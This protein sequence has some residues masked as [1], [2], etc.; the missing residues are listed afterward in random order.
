M[1]SVKQIGVIKNTFVLV[2]ADLNVPLEGKKV[3]DE[4]RIRALVPTLTLLKKKGAKIIVISHIGR[5]PEETLA[6]VAKKLSTYIP[7][8]FVPA[9]FGASVDQALLGMRAGDVIVLENLRSEMGEQSGSVSFA[10]K[11][12]AYADVYV[13]EAFPVSHRKDASIALVPKYLPSFAGLQLE[14]EVKEL[15]KAL[16]PKH[17]FLFILGGAKAET[18]LPLLKKYLSRAD[19]VFVGGVLANDCFKAQGFEVGVSKT[20]THL[21]SLKPILK[22]KKLLLPSE[23]TV[24]RKGAHATISL[25]DMQKSDAIVD[26]GVKSIDALAPHIAKAKL[27]VWNGPMGWYEGGN[28]KA[29][30]ELLKLLA[31]AKGEVIIG[32]GDTAVLVDKKKM[33]DKFTFVST[34][35]GATLEFLATGTLP[36]IAALK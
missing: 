18:K 2:R 7:L 15:G 12:A 9:V 24:V 17:P 34:G 6:P 23:V 27:I 4:S 14:R 19:T 33:A 25:C 32:G 22:N 13:N 21:P 30:L 29:T 1:K 16:A 31:H 35:G 20:D 10:K 5:N 3:R 36:G 8:T 26:I 28:T 11:L